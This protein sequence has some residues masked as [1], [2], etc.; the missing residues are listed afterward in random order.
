MSDKGFIEPDLQFIS[1]IGSEEMKKCYQCSTCAVVCPIT[2][3][4]NPFP[5]KEMIWA[6]WG[7][8]DRL[9]KDPDIFLCHN[10]NDC[11]TNCPR[12]GR[13]GDLLAALRNYFY[14][15]NAY[16]AFLGQW[17]ASPKYLPLLAAIPAF[18]LLAL[19]FIVN[20]TLSFPEGVVEY[21]RMF[22]G[23]FV[24]DPIFVGA[25]LFIVL[26]FSMSISRFWRD[27]DDMAPAG[28]SKMP[29]GQAI[30][31]TI[32]EI[33]AHKKF[34]ECGQAKQRT[35][36]HKLLIYSFI[37]L[38]V[39]TGLV[40][41][42]EWLEIAHEKLGLEFIPVIHSM[43][44]PL[45]LLNP[46]KILANIGAVMLLYGIW[47]AIQNRKGDK[48]GAK[49]GR[50]NYQDWYLLYDILAIVVTGIGAEILRLLSHSAEAVA[51]LAYIV[52]FLHLIAV[53][54]LIAYLP[55]GKFAHIVYRTVAIIHSKHTGRYEL[56]ASDVRG[57][58]A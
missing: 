50:M 17:L 1:D 4:V 52:Y 33:L 24:I 38:A 7:L 29:I 43:L 32:K 11:S 14:R 58:V 13:P 19:S 39:V 45:H 28:A 47:S 8:K 37:I 55:F 36:A 23:L 22:Y 51:P 56:K 44:T 40:M 15:A 25:L 6:Q 20:G 49:F 21:R 5:R 9:M 18:L 10:C 57:S 42:F 54:M 3:E 46:V 35:Q 34:D 53:F 2:P 27:M 30:V 31:E 26:S 48:D 16:P 41:I 12:G